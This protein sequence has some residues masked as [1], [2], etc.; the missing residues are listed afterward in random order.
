M[1][2]TKEEMK[3]FKPTDAMLT[4]TRNVFVTMAFEKTVRPIV[5]GYQKDI[6]AFWKFKIAPE[7]IN[8]GHEENEIILDP[9]NS[10]LMGDDDFKLYLAEC[11]DARKKAGL[12]VDNPEHCPL[13]VAE[14]LRVIAENTLIDTMEPITGISLDTHYLSLE[15]RKQLIDLTLKLL[16]KYIK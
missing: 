1:K 9:K 12:K 6:L 3:N 15:H 10:Y 5:E 11:N 8:R 14:H 7:H 2:I 13:L 16:A 4:A